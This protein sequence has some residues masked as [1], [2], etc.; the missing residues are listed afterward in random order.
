[1]SSLYIHIPFC[2]SKCSYCDFYSVAMRNPEPVVTAILGELEGRAAPYRPPFETL[3]V[4]GGTPTVLPPDELRRLLRGV[5][6]F[7]ADGAEVTVE[8]NPDDITPSLAS[9]LVAEGVNRVSMGVQ[10]LVDS[11]LEAISRRHDAATAVRAVGLLR[12]AGINNISCDLIYGL[13][14]QTQQSFAVSLDSLIALRPQHISAYLLSYEPGTRITRDLAAGRVR[15]ATDTEAEAFYRHLCHSLAEAGY[16]HYEISNF[17]LPGFHSR[18]NSAYWDTTH[19]YLG[20]GPAA[21]SY[22][23]RDTRSANVASAARYLAGQPAE[24]EHLTDEERH[25]ERVMLALRTARGIDP[26]DLADGS[27]TSG[28]VATPDGRLRIPEES[29]LIADS[30]IASLI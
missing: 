15:Q 11:E 7:V 5:M 23:G 25:E 12:D 21:H 29:W 20:L 27:N 26:D 28:L 17:A 22:D 14:G 30:I 8:A 13:P 4:G 6:P 2:R 16:L 3:Y 9:M 18:H 19:P 1:M 24:T 10:S